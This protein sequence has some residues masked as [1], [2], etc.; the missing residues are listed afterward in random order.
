MRIAIVLCLVSVTGLAAVD[1]F[2]CVGPEA[3]PAGP[4][5]P[6]ARLIDLQWEARQPMPTARFGHGA[7]VAN[8]LVY[9]V[10]GYS[11]SRLTLNEVYD[12]AGDSWAVKAP[13]DSMRN[14]CAGAAAAGRVYIAGGYN[15]VRRMNFVE[16]YDPAVNTWRGLAPM[17]YER[18]VP[19]AA[20]LEDM[21]YV[22]A[23][24]AGGAVYPRTVERYDPG[25]ATW[26]TV[27]PMPTGRAGPGAAVID[28]KLYV[29]GGWTG[30]EPPLNT[31]EAYDPASNTWTV[32]PPMPTGR[33]Y[34]SAAAVDGYLFCVGGQISFN[35]PQVDIVEVF[36]TRTGTWSTAT[37]MPSARA[38]LG[39]VAVGGAL[40]SIGGSSGGSA[41]NGN[42]RGELLSALAG[43]GS[44]PA[45]R[46]QFTRNPV[47]RGAGAALTLPADL[48]YA[49]R[50]R[51]YDARG[52]LVRQQDC[53]TGGRAVWDG[54]DSRGMPV[55]A[56]VYLCRVESARGAGSG[57]LVV[58]D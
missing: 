25:T 22:C 47:R 12:P 54:R 56:G 2:G 29:C 16:E 30:T 11:S 8:G 13:M 26:D 28:G 51:V 31:V 6:A 41:Q 53:G 50:L 46:V 9:C 23:G 34:L 24:F 20:G 39:A 44:G 52:A 42:Y 43:P 3:A 58:V 14:G 36:D 35:G 4:P 57:R 5:E 21:L 32:L 40:Y 1:Q 49:A 17:L 15:G 18:T 55:P 48:A 45:L 7:A 38:S 10:G 33:M 27:A 19:A 37:P